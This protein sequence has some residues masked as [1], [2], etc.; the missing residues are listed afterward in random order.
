MLSNEDIKGQRA[1]NHIA[2]CTAVNSITPVIMTYVGMLNPLFLG[3]FYYYQIKYFKS[4]WEFKQN[5]GTQ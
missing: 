3:P 5:E 1:F 2:I 4:V